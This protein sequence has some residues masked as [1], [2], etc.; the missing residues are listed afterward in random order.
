MCCEW[1]QMTPPTDRRPDLHA[2][3]RALSLRLFG[4][5]PIALTIHLVT[6]ASHRLCVEDAAGRAPPGL[7]PIGACPTVPAEDVWAQGPVPKRLS[8]CQRVY[9]PGLGAFRFAKKQAAAVALLWEARFGG[10]D[11]H[12]VEQAVLLR[13][14]D[15]ECNRLADLFR[16]HAGWGVLIIQGDRPGSYRLADLPPWAQEPEE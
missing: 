14:A 11:E 6:G 7:E 16:R 13:E 5:V 9:W 3:V 2:L 8:D 4:A 12:E 1:C 10:G 15:S